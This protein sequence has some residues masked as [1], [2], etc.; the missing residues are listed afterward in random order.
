MRKIL[1]SLI[2]ISF[3]A[4]SFASGLYSVPA[5]KNPVTK[6][7]EVVFPI[8]KNGAKIS[9]MDLSQMSIKDWESISGQ[10][11]KLSQKIGFKLMQKQLRSS[12]NADGT[13]NQKKLEK[14]HQH[15]KTKKAD[16]KTRGYLRLW[17]I[18]LGAAIIFSILG[19][20]VPF[21]WILSAVAGLGAAIFFILWIISMSGAS[22]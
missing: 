2:A 16:D 1:A 7:S 10:K 5:S 8:G 14:M 18:L 20:F 19:I 15:T 12:I 21:L 4:S 9:L 13:I 6:A 11:M 22:I 17:L 3:V